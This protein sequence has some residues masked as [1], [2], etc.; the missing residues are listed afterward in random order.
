MIPKAGTAFRKRSCS[1]REKIMLKKKSV[2]T[3]QREAITLKPSLLRGAAG[4][5][6]ANH[7]GIG[8]PPGAYA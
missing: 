2:M 7:R 3:I 8:K 5:S 6:F 1:R 4:S